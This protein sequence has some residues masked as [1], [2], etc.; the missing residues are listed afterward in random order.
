MEG[1][2]EKGLSKSNKVTNENVPGGRNNAN[3]ENLDQLLKENPGDLTIN[4]ER[5][6]LTN[7]TQSLNNAKK[8]PGSS[9]N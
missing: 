4:V 9:L 7:N 6:D 3:V 2:S 5:N 1:I 8:F